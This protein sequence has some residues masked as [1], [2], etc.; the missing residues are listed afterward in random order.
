MTTTNSI[1]DAFIN[2]LL[3]DAAY[4]SGLVKD[5]VPLTSAQLV[6]KEEFTTRLTPA[7]AQYFVD[8]FEVVTQID[9]NDFFASGFDATVFRS[10]DTYQTYV[11]MR[12]TEFFA[13]GGD[14]A[15]DADLTNS[16]LA[17]AQVVDMVN[18]WLRATSVSPVPQLQIN[19][20]DGAITT[21]A[22]SARVGRNELCELRRMH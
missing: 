4:V 16:G 10:K 19:P 15:A 22:H 20:L 1:H 21:A 6:A 13:G 8:H 14:V 9:T 7:L 17:V 3:A 11:S 5:N 18:W 12:G 2:A